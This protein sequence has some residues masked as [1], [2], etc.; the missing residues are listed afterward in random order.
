MAYRREHG[1]NEI[2]VKGGSFEQDPT[3]YV[4][5]AAYDV[6]LDTATN[7]YVVTPKA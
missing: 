3:P 2:I 1:L 4:D 5:T 7:M 6:T